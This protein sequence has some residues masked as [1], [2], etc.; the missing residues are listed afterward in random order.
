MLR[1]HL[2]CWLPRNCEYFCGHSLLW[3]GLQLF[4]SSFVS[5]LP[6][7]K[8]SSQLFPFP[9]HRFTF[10][11]GQS[12]PP[13]S[14]P[15]CFL[16]SL[17]FVSMAGFEDGTYSKHDDCP[18]AGC[19]DILSQAQR[20]FETEHEVRFDASMHCISHSAHHER[21]LSLRFDICFPCGSL[22][23]CYVTV[24]EPSSRLIFTNGDFYR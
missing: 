1:P 2:D 20:H 18:P 17:S 8:T 9:H 24:K 15:F 11:K 22:D 4:S 23:S 16:I 10:P 19:A 13:S 3:R 5:D 6:I 12:Y 21:E 7:L 14:Y